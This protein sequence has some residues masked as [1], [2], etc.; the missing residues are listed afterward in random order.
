MPNPRWPPLAV[1]AAAFLLTVLSL[2][3]C[4]IRTEPPRPPTFN[5]VN[6][7]AT[8]LTIT[9]DGLPTND[10]ERARTIEPHNLLSFT[11]YPCQGT[12]ITATTLDGR[13]VATLA[14]PLCPHGLWVIEADGHAHLEDS[15]KTYVAP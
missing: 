4:F 7:M 2:S 11:A 3:G 9:V 15:R 5:V 8:A 12:G 13:V 14:Q 10:P 1:R 6:R